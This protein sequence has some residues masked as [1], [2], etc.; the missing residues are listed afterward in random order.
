MNKFC[1]HLDY[2]IK[3]AIERIDANNNRVVIALNSDDKV[4]GVISQ[5]DIIRALLSG[6]GLYALI[7]TIVK[8]NFM[9]LN[10]KDMAEAYKL[11]KKLKI[12]LLPIVDED[13]HLIDVITLDDVYEYMEN[14]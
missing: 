11:F 3:E 6:T 13:F 1:V 10:T 12:S 8:P 4:V 2:T 5:G 14:K 7:E 9:Y